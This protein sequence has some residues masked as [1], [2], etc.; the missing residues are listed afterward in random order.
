MPRDVELGSLG[1]VT[2]LLRAF[3]IAASLA[4]VTCAA[5]VPTAVSIEFPELQFDIPDPDI[6]FRVPASETYLPATPGKPALWHARSDGGSFYLFGAIQDGETSNVELGRRAE[7]A[8]AKSE[9]LVVE[10]GWESLPRAEQ[11]LPAAGLES[12]RRVATGLL[13]RARSEGRNGGGKRIVGLD[14]L[15]S[16]LQT[17]AELPPPARERL[18]R[19]TRVPDAEGPVD[20]SSLVE[21]WRRGDAGALS[22]LFDPPDPEAA[23]LYERLI[24]RRNE[25]MATRLD[26][27]ATDGKERFVAV[28]L[29]HLVGRRGVPALLA[30][31]GYRV[32][33]LD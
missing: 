13:A 2:R 9:E 1:N 22:A 27:L 21:S 6:V 8:Y 26:A 28:G 17:V 5:E 3:A 4:S 15:G 31:R 24:F 23:L 32:E 19:E 20:P 29:L 25:E 7:E 18:L 30:G 11:S 16:E 10:T 33:R 12:E 14:T